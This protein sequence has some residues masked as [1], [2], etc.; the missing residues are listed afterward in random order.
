M[1]RT[2]NLAGRVLLAHIFVLSGWS[3]I[4]GYAGTQAYMASVGLPGTLLPL[5]IALELLGGLGLIVG[6]KTRWTALALAAFSVI[7]ALVF[8]NN[9]ADQMQ[10]ISFMKNLTIAGGLLVLAQTGAAAPSVDAAK[11]FHLSARHARA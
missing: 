6:F 2:F 5:V 9:F 1:E 3:K 7:A 4:A 10:L 8:H 11:R